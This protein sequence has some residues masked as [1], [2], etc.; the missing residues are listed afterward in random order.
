MRT[1]IDEYYESK[2]INDNRSELLEKKIV[3]LL[4]KNSWPGI[5][6]NK[7]KAEKENLI[8]QDLIDNA[9]SYLCEIKNSQ[10]RTGLHVFGVNQSMDK[11]IELT[12]TISNVPTGT[13]LGLTQCLAEDLGFTF[14]PWSDE[15]SKNLKQVDIDLFKA[16]QQLMQGKS[17]K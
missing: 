15:E 14:D 8:I 17:V 13:N 11:L 3:D 10:I 9:E 12:F 7:L 2:L 4:I 5:E 16:I 1:L 6:S